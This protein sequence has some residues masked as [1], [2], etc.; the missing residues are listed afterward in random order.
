L[1][2]RYIE[3]ARALGPGRQSD[4]ARAAWRHAT[5]LLTAAASDAPDNPETRK[6]R[7]N[8]ANDFAW[9]LLHL[10][11]ADEEAVLLALRLA[12]QATESQP[13]CG[14]YWNTLGNA[15]YR[16]GNHGAAIM[17]L[18]RSIELTGGG[19]GADYLLMAMAH[20]REG[21]PQEARDWYERAAHW[22]EQHHAHD[23]DL[24]A[25]SR[26]AEALLN[27]GSLMTTSSPGG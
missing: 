14:A 25:L 18:E 16:A 3:L 19:T 2:L 27:P 9:F 1:A 10:P 24:L 20:A 4:K 15:Q 22:I 26:E 23:A 21:R 17:A 7:W 8:C 13:E 11:V 12:M 6:L 5:E